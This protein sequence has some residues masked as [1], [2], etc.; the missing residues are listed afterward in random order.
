MHTCSLNKS[1]LIFVSCRDPNAVYIY[2]FESLCSVWFFYL[3]SFLFD[4]VFKKQVISIC[5][6]EKTCHNPLSVI[7]LFYCCIYLYFFNLFQDLRSMNNTTL[8][9]CWYN[10]CF[11]RIYSS[12]VT[13]NKIFLICSFIIFP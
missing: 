13:N 8:F 5:T 2:S 7:C 4:L 3:I 6:V 9:L 12:S 1:I 11:S 10:F